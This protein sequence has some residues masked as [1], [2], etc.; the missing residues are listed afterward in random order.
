[1]SAMVILP[2]QEHRGGG[3]RWR[4]SITIRGGPPAGSVRDVAVFE[5]ED[6]V[7]NVHERLVVGGHQGR[8]SLR[9]DDGQQQA[10]DLA[11]GDLHDLAGTDPA[12]GLTGLLTV[13]ADVTARIWQP[14]QR[15]QSGAHYVLRR[16]TAGCGW[17]RSGEADV[18]VEVPEPEVEYSAASPVHDE[19]QQDDGQDYDDH[20]EEEHDDAGDG[21]PGYSS[22][23]SHGHQLPT[24]ARPIR[25]GVHR[26]EVARSWSIGGRYHVRRAGETAQCWKMLRHSLV[27]RAEI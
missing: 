25:A 16:A 8:D 12:G 5:A 21:I 6:L 27:R 20:P 10:H 4:R 18:Q 3:T 17:V 11:V 26:D 22:R 13:G 9:T 15:A 24:N 19:R 2:W 23:S 1:M 7:S 14:V